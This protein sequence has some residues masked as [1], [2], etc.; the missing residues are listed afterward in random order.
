MVLL[1][2]G[3]V[4]RRRV[5]ITIKAHLFDGLFRFPLFHCLV[6]KGNQYKK[7]FLDPS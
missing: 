6:M 2:C 4:G 3:R 7:V 1:Y 5:F